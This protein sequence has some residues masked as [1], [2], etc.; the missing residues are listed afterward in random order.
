LR[1]FNR[2]SEKSSQVAALPLSVIAMAEPYVTRF[3]PSPTGYL[4]LGHAFSALF[5]ERI[6]RESGGKFLLRIEDTDPTRCKPEFESAIYEDLNWLGLKWETPVRRQ[7]DHF[8]DYAVALRKLDEAGLV[9]PCFCTR[10]EIAA[11]IAVSVAAPHGVDGPIYPGTC[12]SLSKATVEERARAGT[13]NAQ[14]LNLDKALR[15]LGGRAL[16][17]VESGEGANEKTGT[18]TAAP[19]LF[20]DFVLARKDTPTSYHLAV[21]HDDALQGVTLVT[22]GKDIFPATSIQRLLQELLGLPTPEYRHH[23]LLTD[24]SGKRFAKRDKSVTLRELRAGG[25]TA[26]EIRTRLGFA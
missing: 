21:V 14:R 19:E 24:E 17:F 18:I 4:H 23:R 6:A 22:R 16:H 2:G 1:D 26:S 9:Y 15:L 12:R 3:A 13:P 25:V 20:G 10:A 5:A 8:A 7:S 11:E